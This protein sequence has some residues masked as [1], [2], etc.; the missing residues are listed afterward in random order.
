MDEATAQMIIET[1]PEQ[2]YRILSGYDRDLYVDTGNGYNCPL[3]HYFCDA[4]MMEPDSVLVTMETVKLGYRGEGEF[5]HPLPQWMN[6]YQE[7]ITGKNWQTTIGG[8]LDVLVTM[9]PEAAEVDEKEE[10]EEMGLEECI[11]QLRANYGT[12]RDPIATAVY[13]LERYAAGLAY[14]KERNG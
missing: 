14:E 6:D 13:F 2:V 3:H 7:A 12:D 10:T 8:C 1:T 9:Y 4:L 11:A 5:Y